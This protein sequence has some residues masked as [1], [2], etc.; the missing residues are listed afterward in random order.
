M[1]LNKELILDVVYPVGAIYMSVNSTNP[2]TLFGGTWEQIEGKFLLGNATAGEHT[3]LNNLGYHYDAGRGTH[4]VENVADGS[5]V[6]E[7]SIVPNK[8]GYSETG[9][10]TYHT[11][12]Q[13]GGA[14]ATAIYE[15]SQTDSQVTTKKY[16]GYNLAVATAS[17]VQSH[18]DIKV[19]AT[20]WEH[21]LPPYMLCYIW[22]RTS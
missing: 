8:Q 17:E 7:H 14:N 10:K 18:Q 3:D 20:F 19:N 1:T 21:N 13:T 15:M 22:K 12:W 4:W 11:H 16:V 5:G 2:S 9:G 6:I